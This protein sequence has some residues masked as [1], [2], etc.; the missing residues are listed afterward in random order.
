MYGIKSAAVLNLQRFVFCQFCHDTDA[1]AVDI[2]V[3]K[4]SQGVWSGLNLSLC[5]VNL[6]NVAGHTLP[7]DKLAEM[8]ALMAMT[9]RLYLPSAFHFI[10]V[11]LELMHLGLR[12]T[13]AMYCYMWCTFRSHV[14]VSVCLLVTL[15][16][17]AENG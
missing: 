6:G 4:V 9:V 14:S 12:R 1:A 13:D 10:V 15:V 2:A 17:H 11:S 16:S 3:G 5:A 7:T 8:Y